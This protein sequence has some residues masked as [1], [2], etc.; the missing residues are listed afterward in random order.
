MK[1]NFKVGQSNELI[2]VKN[3]YDLH[4][5]YDYIGVM[6]RNSTQDVKISF[7]PNSTYGKDEAQISLRFSKVSF[8]EFSSNF[9]AQIINNI[10]EIGYKKEGDYDDE[11]LLTE[12]QASGNDHLFFR[13]ENNHFIR[14]YSEF[15]ALEETEKLVVLT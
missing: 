6:I 2:T 5:M 9:G 10:D 8:L 4:N 11:W 7:V 12:V 14:I 13:L 3:T 1:K 15:V